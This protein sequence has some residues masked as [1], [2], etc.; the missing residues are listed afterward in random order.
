MLFYIRRYLAAH[1]YYPDSDVVN[2]QVRLTLQGGRQW[3]GVW[4]FVVEGGK[5]MLQQVDS[6]HSAGNFNNGWFLAMLGD[7]E[8]TNLSY[9]LTVTESSTDAMALMAEAEP[10]RF[11]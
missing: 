9:Y 1:N 4:D 6:L 5:Y 2:G 3:A 10:V 11:I 7:A 8:R